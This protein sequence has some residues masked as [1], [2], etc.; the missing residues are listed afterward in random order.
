MILFAVMLF[1][2]GMWVGAHPSQAPTRA[3]NV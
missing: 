3:A 1:P 2:P